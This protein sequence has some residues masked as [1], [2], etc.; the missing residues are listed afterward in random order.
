MLG[1]FS[2]NSGMLNTILT[3]FSKWLDLLAATLGL[4]PLKLIGLFG[5]EIVS[6]VILGILIYLIFIKKQPEGD[7]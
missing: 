4:T 6:D 7:T 3:S 2:Y 5:I 1:K